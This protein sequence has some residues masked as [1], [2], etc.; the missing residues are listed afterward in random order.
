[1]QTDLSGQGHAGLKGSIWEFPDIGGT[2]F[3]Y[4]RKPPISTRVLYMDPTIWGFIGPG[5]LNQV[6]TLH[7]PINLRL[8]S[9]NWSH[10]QIS[11]PHTMPAL[12]AVLVKAAVGLFMLHMCF[13]DSFTW[14]RA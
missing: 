10:A 13:N 14:S 3:P 11:E 7:D 2:L 1:M 5:F 8:C 12:S 9:L 4:V 6:P